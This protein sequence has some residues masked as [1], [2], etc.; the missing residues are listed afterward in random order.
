MASDRQEKS[1]D[2]LCS[3]VVDCP[4]S[5]PVWTE[6]GVVVLRNQNIKGGRLDLSS[7][8]FTDE[9]HFQARIKRATPST[10]DIIITREAPMGDVC[11]IP[12]GLRCC[13]GQ[14]QVLLRPNPKRV[15]GRYLLYTLQS[16]YVQHQIGWNEGTG[17]TVSNLRIPVLEAL[18]IPTP[19]LLEQN[20]IARILGTLDDKIELNR[21]SNETLEAM[22]RALFKDWFVDFGPTH[23]KMQGQRP[24]LS[25]DIWALFPDALDE[26][27]KP[28]GWATVPL[29]DLIELNPKEPLRKGTPAPYL[30]MASLPTSGSWPAQ[31]VERAF[32]SGM[33]FRNRDTLLAR[34]TPCL[35]NGKTAF[36]Q[37]LADDEIA[38]GSTE[39][40]I[41]R[42]RDAVPA[43]YSYLLAR[44][45]SFRAH[46]IRSMTGTSGR[47]RVQA[48]SIAS[49]PVQQAP[50]AVF[51]A[52]GALVKPWFESFKAR[53]LESETLA[54]LRDTL[55][56]KLLSG[57]LRVGDVEKRL[58]A[59]S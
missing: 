51:Y 9:A 29:S 4:H 11:Q 52:F 42:S 43:E 44:N 12:D 34:I 24:Y 47:Q 28:K 57:E 2:E 46:A 23:A 33:R 1:L 27:G 50:D 45:P 58:E 39:Y 48:E 38:W 59:V 31:P 5:T 55:L 18:K 41:M 40:I 35:E 14:R 21:R 10:G 30:D 8:S 56:P 22:A 3:A 54:T 36:I 17:S 32:G 20:A 49:Y 16:N 19:S 25:P 26:E 13:L 37:Y 15:D 53:A 6:S 7:P